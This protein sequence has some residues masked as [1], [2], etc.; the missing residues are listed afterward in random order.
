MSLSGINFSGIGSGID[1][2]NIISQLMSLQRRPITVIQ[3]RQAQIQQHQAAVNGIAA[4]VSGLQAASTR[5]DGSLA[6]TGVTA[7]TGDPLIA[8]ASA[9]PGAQAAT[10]SLDVT[11]LARSHRIASANQSSQTAALGVAGQIVVNGKAINVGLTDSLTAIAG[12]INNAKTGVNASVVATSSNTFN[13]VLTSE[14]TG[15]DNTISVADSGGGTILSSTIGLITSSVT[16][17]NPVTNGAATNLFKD[18]GTSIATLLGQTSASA[19]TVQ[20]NGTGVAIDFSVDTLSTIASKI[21]AAGIAGVTASAVTATDPVTK[22]ARQEL[23]IVGAS[24]TPT[25]VDSNNILTNL[26]V[27]Q[28]GFTNQTQAAR[29]ATFVINGL[30]A[31]RSSNSVSDVI[32]G[33]TFN[34][35]KEASSTTVKVSADTEGIKKDIETFV[36]A[37]NTLARKVSELSQFDTQTLSTGVLFGDVTIQNVVNSVANAVTGAV[38]GLSGS[39]TVLAQVGNTLDGTGKLNIDSSKLSDA[40][41]TKLSEVAKLF[42]IAGTAT[43]N[44]I[45]FVSASDKTKSSNSSGYT[46]NIT[47][48]ASQASAVA[49]TAHTAN[50]NTNSE[51]LTFTG[52]QFGASGKTVIISPNASLDDIISRINSDGIISSVVTASSVS[53]RLSLAAKSYG[54]AGTFTVRS[55]QAAA[56]NNSGLGNVDVSATGQDVGGT[57]NGELAT[58]KGQFLTGDAG[59]A[60]TNGLQ[61]RVAATLVGSAGSIVLTKGVANLLRAYGSASTNSVDGTLTN[62]SNS[63]DR[64]VTDYGTDIKTLQ[65]RLKVEET[66]LRLRFAAMEGA[67]SRIRAAGNGLAGLTNSL[68]S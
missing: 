15:A 58:G 47:R 35:I 54:S 41:N 65:E 28:N 43:D 12:N 68:P 2:E 30:A 37:Y 31:S 60:S 19:G 66:R 1:T 26:G 34:L 45:S 20:I 61:I 17:Q 16:V 42:K 18:S 21:N 22:E 25:F 5:L 10:H 62:Y 9:A 32:S 8:T 38:T 46:V 53:G 56:A 4:L 59:N 40:L 64:Q 49:G 57:I 11:L 33:L 27:L 51:V 36:N 39:T 24:G 67:I 23:R 13:L 55:S 3:Q 63:L 29:D 50:D 48:V 14:T 7:S 52:G 6:F 44:S